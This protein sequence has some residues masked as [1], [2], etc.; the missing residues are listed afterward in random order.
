MSVDAL[1]ANLQNQFPNLKKNKLASPSQNV[2]GTNF[3]A[4]IEEQQNFKKEILEKGFGTV[5]KEQQ[6]EKLEEEIKE[7][8]LSALGLSE[9]QFNALPA[10]QKAAI[11][12]AIKEAMQQEMLNRS[13]KH[14][15]EEGTG[16]PANL[17]IPMI[18]GLSL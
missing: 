6:Q 13:R 16:K 12:Q 11:E 4:M 8:I 15:E 18:A 14:A 2:Q 17:S 7:K 1:V 3:Q 5:I 10:A 9:E